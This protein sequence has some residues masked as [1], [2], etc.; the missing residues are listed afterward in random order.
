M[1]VSGGV[2][3]VVAAAVLQ[4]AASQVAFI[5]SCPA[6]NV[7]QNFDVT[8]YL[9]KWYELEKYFAIFELGG[10]CITATYSDKGNNK[11]RVL[12]EQISVFGNIP[13]NIV[14]T[15]QFVNLQSGEAKLSVSFDNFL[16]AGMGP[17]GGAGNYWVLETDYQNY[18]V[19]WSC[20]DLVAVNKQ[21]L[22]ILWRTPKPDPQLLYYVKNLIRARGLSLSKLEPTDQTNCP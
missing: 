17:V 19:V 2:R 16:W 3:V 6:Q 20:Q 18:S 8:S 14:G 22:W 13:N 10:R 11:I 4:A 1:M 12:N 7:V 15:A 21:I 5:G 9:G